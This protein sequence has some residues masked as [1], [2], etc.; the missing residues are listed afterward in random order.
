[1]K[2]FKTF[3]TLLAVCLASIG[4]AVMSPSAEAICDGRLESVSGCTGG[5]PF[6]TCNGTGGADVIVGSLSCDN[7]DGTS[8]C[9]INGFGGAD[10]LTGSAAGDSIC[11]GAQSD[12]IFAGAGPDRIFGGGDGDIILGQGAS[13]NQSEQG[14]NGVVIGGAAFDPSDCGAGAFDVSIESAFN[15]N[16]EFVFVPD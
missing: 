4:T 6:P 5:T 16:C 10:V 15:T 2:T 7:I 3:K 14:G 12:I 13:D 1:M 8:G 9:V 11:G